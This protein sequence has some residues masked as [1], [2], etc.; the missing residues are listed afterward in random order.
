MLNKL[1]NIV[2]SKVL[3]IDDHNS[4]IELLRSILEGANYTVLSATNNK[5]IVQIFEVDK[6]V[7]IVLN[8]SISGL[9]LCKTIK[10]NS[11][12]NSI[13]IIFICQLNDEES[14]IMFY[15]AG[16]SDY[17]SKPYN[18]QEVILRV[19]A[20]ITLS[21]ERNNKNIDLNNKI[22]TLEF[23]I[24]KRQ[25]VEKALIVSKNKYKTLFNLSPV[26]IGVAEQTGKIIAQN[27]AME[28][29]TGYTLEELNEIGLDSLY[30]DSK[31]RL[32][33]IEE[34]NKKGSIRDFETK[35]K[36]K[37]NS[38]YYV[39]LNVDLV[40][41]ENQKYLFTYQV[42]I[43]E[44]KLAE[45][46]ILESE[47]KFRA[48]F[49]SSI[50]AIGVT[51]GLKHVFVNPS[52]LKLFGYSFFSEFKTLT[53]IELFAHSE[54]EYILS[55]I[56]KRK[57]GEPVPNIFESIGLK[58]NGTEFPIEI[59]ISTY[60]LSGINY[61]VL[62]FRDITEH[63]AAQAALQQSEE[64][65]RKMIDLSPDGVIVHSGG[66]ILFANP[67]SFKLMEAESTEQLLNTI[68]INFVHPD[69]RALTIRRIKKINETGEPSDYSEEKFI[70]L[71]NNIIDVEVI[72]IPIN[73]LGRLSI[74]T[75]I[76]DISERKKHEFVLKQK[77]DELERFNE[78]TIDRELRMIEL[79]K[80]INNLLLQLNKKPKFEIS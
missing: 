37:N 45:K 69:F 63:N 46:A 8:S 72:G 15:K 16:C 31:D 59:N 47:I 17:I 40:E 5:S 62:I 25:A 2:K 50:D 19:A 36:H 1:D 27:K 34:L 54:R 26:G 64:N 6:P 70:T 60:I 48:I 80:E 21:E 49:E 35:L 12:L 13:P 10:E 20:Q 4:D 38:D 44:R 66:K 43:T 67:A 76:R 77:V 53:V 61:S 11:K 29:M 41:L 32:I 3:I 23:D 79:K 39:L 75:I 18:P 71:K 52:Y 14:K 42:N 65:F 58:N 22:L 55:N 24:K 7:L 73:Y 74:Q 30:I 57:N 78:I 68:A 56:Q 28:N 51:N 9:E 33:L